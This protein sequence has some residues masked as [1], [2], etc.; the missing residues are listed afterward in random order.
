MIKKML[1]ILVVMAMAMVVNVP[2]ASAWFFELRDLADDHT[3]ELYFDPEGTTLILESYTLGFEFDE[4]EMEYVSYTN[5]APSPLTPDNMGPVDY[6]NNPYGSGTSFLFN[7]NASSTTGEATVTDRFLLGTFEFTVDSTIIDGLNDM[8]FTRLDG[9]DDKA[10]IDGV[11][12]TQIDDPEHFVDGPN[13]SNVPIPSAALLLGSG[14][15]GLIGI[16]RRKVMGLRA[17]SA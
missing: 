4:I 9:T 2:G 17:E 6:Y 10:R 7:F 11:Y 3:A 5:N 13:L 8:R 12:Y 16:G 14:L 1:A 15:L